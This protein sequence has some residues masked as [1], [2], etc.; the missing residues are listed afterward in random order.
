MPQSMHS[1]PQ[2]PRIHQHVPNPTCSIQ[3]QCFSAVW[4][5]ATM[6]YIWI[7]QHECTDHPKQQWCVYV[8]G[9]RLWF[10]CMWC[11]HAGCVLYVCVVVCKALDS[12]YKMHH[13][14]SL[15]VP[16][17]VWPFFR[18]LNSWACLHLPAIWECL[19]FAV[20]MAWMLPHDGC[21]FLISEFTDAR[22]TNKSEFLKDSFGQKKK[23]I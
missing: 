9:I 7:H 23:K 14:C 8:M 22:T 10:T 6:R 12:Y 4:G 18:W 1:L 15:C 17:I 16:C 3:K 21:S 19:W 20:L 5:Q 11:M 2:M 13:S